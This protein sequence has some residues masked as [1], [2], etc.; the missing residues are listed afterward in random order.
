M[1]LVFRVS[2]DE[3]S[4]KMFRKTRVFASAETR[5]AAS[6]CQARPENPHAAVARTSSLLNYSNTIGAKA[7]W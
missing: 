3:T 2:F 1:V 6:A 4:G 7:C 5:G